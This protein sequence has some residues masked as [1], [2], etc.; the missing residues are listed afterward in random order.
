MRPLLY[1]FIAIILVSCEP[2]TENQ[3]AKLTELP[4]VIDSSLAIMPIVAVDTSMVAEDDNYATYYV[5]ILDSSKNYYDLHQKMFELHNTLKIPIDTMGRYFNATKNLIALPDN[6]E[7]EIYAGEY[8]QRRFPS[9]NLSIEYL[10]TYKADASKN[11][12]CLVTG[13]Y[14]AS[15]FADTLCSTL[16]AKESKIFVSK[17]KLYI[18]CT[19]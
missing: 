15:S 12:M 14:T 13:I 4:R 1:L 19:H 8:L 3:S 17:S 2:S 16:K 5:V 18:G 10:Q 7:D 9:E 11:M 6:D